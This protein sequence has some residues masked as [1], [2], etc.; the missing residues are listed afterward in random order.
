MPHPEQRHASMWSIDA[1]DH[2]LA[3]LRR[4]GPGAQH[5][6]IG[7]PPQLLIVHSASRGADA[8]AP[9]ALDPSSIEIRHLRGLDPVAEMIGIE[10]STSWRVIGVRA[11]ASSR[12]FAD[13]DTPGSTDTRADPVP[14]E[15][16]HLLDRSGTSIT[17]LSI[18]GAETVRLGPDR[19]IREGRIADACRRVFGLP[20]APPPA[21][22]TF[23]V[24]AW[25][26][27]VLRQSLITPGLRWVDLVRL[28]FVAQLAA[29]RTPS[30]SSGP[31]TPSELARALGDVA[32]TLDWARYRDACI[33]LGGCPISDLSPTE[34]SWMD[35]G[36]FARW[37]HSAL[38]ST[39]ELLDLLE[40]T[41]DPGAHDR[42][43]ATVSLAQRR[44][45]TPPSD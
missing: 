15:F 44:S 37:A 39:S 24:D 34:I 5:T 23:I 21:M 10:A 32:T 45:P 3:E 29:E 17:E 2:L 11:P 26:T 13:A 16:I 14:C 1:L 25:L 36:M 27:L 22:A 40:A 8:G 20:T 33:A 30:P 6:G 9:D 31:Q 35:T 43:W 28:D 42:L 18:D 41:I 12:R 7:I 38:P 19:S 4:C